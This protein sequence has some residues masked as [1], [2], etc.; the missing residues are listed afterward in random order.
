MFIVHSIRKNM[1]KHW[2][3]SI[4]SLLISL[5]L[6][7]FLL[8][9]LQNIQSNQA[10]LI[11]LGETIPV[12]GRVCNIDGSQEVGLEIDFHKVHQV[13]ETGLVSDAVIT[14]QTYGRETDATEEDRQLPP[15]INIIG[16]NTFD[17]F[18]A[19][20]AEDVSFI[21]GFNESYLTGEEEICIL[22]DSYMENQGIEPGE[23]FE[24]EV[25]APKYTDEGGS[26]F[27]YK[28]MGIKK[29]KAIGSLSTGNHNGSEE[30]PDILCP[31]SYIE[32]IYEGT[33]QKPYASSVRFALRDPLRMNEFKSEMLAIGFTSVNIS[34]GFSHTGK[35]LTMNDQTFVLA[36]SQLKES[37]TMLQGLAPL[38]FIIVVVIGFIASYLLMQS[39]RNEFAIMRSLGTGKKLCF[40]IIFLE[41]LVL[42]L[43]GSIIGT[44]I[45]LTIV[46]VSFLVTSLI[47]VGFLITYL[48]G[49]AIALFL[50]NRFSVMA[51]LT[52][53]D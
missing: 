21:D 30:L 52:K 6:I 2:K 27:T 43:L 40:A 37:L 50:L 29:L 31:I 25:Y 48:L 15:P 36:A 9:Y 7:L 26:S 4:L 18:Q 34:G 13:L 49:T 22:R 1:M 5:V 47:L 16:A 17:A 20:T 44:A 11:K 41:S 42:A 14:A 35:A 10:Q 39:R 8:L 28:L 46:E 53:T 24:L 38:I 51:I 19:F 12:T 23:E 33:S 32:G 45:A 3:K